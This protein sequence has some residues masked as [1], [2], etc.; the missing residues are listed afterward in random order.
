MISSRRTLVIIGLLLISIVT[1]A[2]NTQPAK[3]DKET[4]FI[5]AD[6]SI[7]PAEAPIVTSDN[8]TYTLTGDISYPAYY[9][10]VVQRSN[11]IIDGE[12]YTVQGN[13]S[14]N[15]LYLSSINNVTIKNTNIK[16]FTNGIY[17]DHSSNS[18]V[19][20]NN[21][22]TNISYGIYVNSS[23]Y[24]SMS[25]NNITMNNYGIGIYLEYTNYGSISAN[26]IASSDDG[27][28]L[29]G[30]NDSII[31]G[32]NVTTNNKG[33]FTF[34]SSNNTFIG[35][36][37]TQDGYGIWLEWFSSD[38][39]VSG[40][41][42]TANSGNGIYVDSS[43]YNS[44][45]GN[46]IANNKF[47]IWVEFSSS[48]NT[49]SRNNITASSGAGV[50]LSADYNSVIE[51]NITE[52]KEF[53][54][55]LDGF[56]NSI[57]ANNIANNGEGIGVWPNSMYNG[58]GGN[59]ITNNSCGIDFDEATDNSV[60][61][62]NITAN[63]YAGI[64]L[65]YSSSNNII[66]GNTFTGDGLS[67]QDSYKNS[68]EN[69]TVNGKPLVYLEGAANYSL[70][71]AGQVI[72]VNCDSI[73]VE[74]LNLSNASV[75]AQLWQTNNTI[76]SG[77]DL[78]A[79]NYCGI[80]LSSS[81]N[82]S[83]SGNSV[84]AKSKFGIWLYSSF[85]GSISGNN[86]TDND[87]G[88][89]LTGSFSNYIIGNNVTANNY[90]VRL[91]YSSSNSLA[92]NNM[93]NDSDGI[94][95]YDSSNNNSISG[96]KITAN[97]NAGVEL[98]SSSSNSVRG[99]AFTDCGLSVLD[100]YKNSVENNTVN[101]KPLVYLEGVTD[102]SVGDAGQ[103][104]LVN[105]ESIRVEN[106]NL[107]RTSI[108]VQLWETNN[109][110][111]TGN[112]ITANSQSGIYIS[113]SNNNTISRN[114]IANNTKGIVVDSSS[115]NEIYHNNFINNTSQVSI[116][117]YYS[118]SVNA[119]DDGYPS[120]G[121]YW[122]DPNNEDIYSGPNQNVTGSDGI[123]DTVYYVD[124]SN[125]D[126]FPLMGGFSDFSVAQGVDVLVVSNSTIS[127]F[128]FNGT[129]ILFNVSGANGTEGF[130]NVCVPTALVDST[131]IVLVN[132]TLVR[133]NLLPSSNRAQTYLYFTY[134]HSIEQ[135]MITPELS[136]S[137]ILAV[138]MLTMLPTIAI[139]KKR[140][141]ANALAD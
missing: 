23:N 93:I 69:N 66:S 49:I 55:W 111:I 22:T 5:E 86:V 54:I 27:I 15:G 108:G 21:I 79:N 62:N 131:L 18:S 127:D 63:K 17:L 9:G 48:Y 16:N 134:G 80:W 121:N 114:N 42:I 40:N 37:I 19:S 1:L 91:D 39:S 53:G 8:I 120:G 44:I 13:R 34:S 45:S 46:I 10:T 65:A 96:N 126:H 106:L 7:S 95:L 129:A 71:D 35:N 41:M 29:L 107:S 104:I 25:D 61:G 113:S 103:V 115:S 132:G 20:G 72:L 123:G 102:L 105:C 110:I 56:H 50:E 24:D 109:T 98:D 26:N 83:I 130:C 11:I 28:R 67:V 82:D 88:I 138:F 6:G 135:V 3:A 97:N 139:H 43:N 117:Y 89:Y 4:V 38:N 90:G 32:N 77:N 60:S 94:D 125:V 84:A 118:S 85:N 101:G 128:Q 78:T 124:Y 87:Y 92:G 73:R 31:T 100:S 116:Y 2:F 33:I 137:L 136:D 36:S 112:N 76:I 57:S 81:S 122:S 59:S 119:W 51:N 30:S 70:N 68:V 47:G 75:G 12:G 99:N 52:N 133:Y 14:A 64:E 140:Q 141:R 74:N 58:I